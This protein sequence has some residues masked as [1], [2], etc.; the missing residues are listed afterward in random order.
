[1]WKIQC[2]RP[3]QRTRSFQ[4]SFSTMPQLGVSTHKKMPQLGVPLVA[5]KKHS[6]MFGFNPR[7]IFFFYQ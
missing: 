5:F 4:S 3:K 7:L 1:M 6:G 2:M